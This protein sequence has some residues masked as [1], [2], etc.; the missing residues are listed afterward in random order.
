MIHVIIVILASGARSYD[1]DIVIER[2]TQKGEFG[3]RFGG[4]TSTNK[5]KINHFLI[6][7]RV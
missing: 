6:R 2:A 5:T 4:K 7:C 3:R 1:V